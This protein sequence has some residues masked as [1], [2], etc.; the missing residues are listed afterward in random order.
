MTQE[1][2]CQ[3]LDAPRSFVGK[4]ERG[5]RRIDVIEL[6]TICR[7]LNLDFIQFMM[8][9]QERQQRQSSPPHPPKLVG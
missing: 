7:A 8:E 4:V 9:L 6:Q 3:K 2:V 5:E 1:E